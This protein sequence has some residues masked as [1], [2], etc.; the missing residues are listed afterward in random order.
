MDRGTPVAELRAPI[1]SVPPHPIWGTRLL[2]PAPDWPTEGP[3]KKWSCIASP[4]HLRR[5][6]KDS[7]RRWTLGVRGPGEGPLL[8]PMVPGVGRLPGSPTMGPNL[9]K[10]RT[11]IQ[12]LPVHIWCQ[13]EHTWPR[14]ATS[15]N[16]F[17]IIVY[18]RLKYTYMYE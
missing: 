17:P 7:P 10:P 8:S 1:A 6:I 14:I 15:S 5:M 12:A 11:A 3:G 18:N 9:T 2:L 16:R 13:N 4:G